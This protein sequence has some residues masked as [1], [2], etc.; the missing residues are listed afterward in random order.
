MHV[1]NL[2]ELSARESLS[3]IDLYQKGYG[4][5]AA[6]IARDA[7]AYAQSPTNGDPPYA[8]VLI[9]TA[10]RA[11]TNTTLMS[12]LS[13]F[14]TL[15]QPDKIIM[16]GEALAGSDLL[17]QAHDF[18]RALGAGRTLDGFLISKVDTV[19]AN[20]GALVRRGACDGDPGVVGWGRAAL[21]GYS[22]LQCGVGGGDVVEGL[23]S[24]R[25]ALQV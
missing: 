24:R 12:S 13:K 2:K 23:R 21:S 10:G 22:E 14:V 11:H 15:A 5:D 17:G 25:S 3:Q 9:D 6:T 18:S 1:R 4:K 19:D 7:V 16:V 20:V 8:V